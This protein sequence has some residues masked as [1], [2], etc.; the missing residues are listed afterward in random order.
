MKKILISKQEPRGQDL[1]GYRIVDVQEEGSTYDVESFLEWK[2]ISNDSVQVDYYW[3]D[4]DTNTARLE[5][6]YVIPQ[7]TLDELA[8][9]AEGN[10]TEKYV[11]NWNTDAW[12]KEAL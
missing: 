10:P 6:D 12:T 8:L 7:D 1:R 4:P 3:Y 5:P 11:W 2:D 9:D